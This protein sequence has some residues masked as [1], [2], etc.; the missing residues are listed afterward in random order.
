MMISMFS[1]LYRD[2]PIE[3]YL[4]FSLA[5]STLSLVT[6]MFHNTWANHPRVLFRRSLAC[7]EGQSFSWAPSYLITTDFY[8]ITPDTRMFHCINKYF[9]FQPLFQQC[10]PWNIQCTIAYSIENKAIL[11]VFLVLGFFKRRSPYLNPCL[12]VIMFSLLNTYAGK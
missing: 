8:E 5:S 6:Q 4:E 12:L 1:G 2:P 7:F 11:V 9:M 10:V 3:L